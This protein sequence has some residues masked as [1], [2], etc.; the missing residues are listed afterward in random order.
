MKHSSTPVTGQIFGSM[1]S[2]FG[3][4]SSTLF[5]FSGMYSPAL[6]ADGDDGAREKF[7][8]TVLMPVADSISKYS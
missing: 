2:T 7:L 4:M 5:G 3:S 1:S 6:N 8:C